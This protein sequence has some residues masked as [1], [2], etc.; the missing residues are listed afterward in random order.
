MKQK[1]L[2]FLSMMLLIGLVGA[3]F[4]TAQD[5]GIQDVTIRDL[6]TYD[7]L[8]SVLDIPDHPLA[9]EQVRITFVVVS[10][11]RTSGLASFN[12]NN[13]PEIGRIHI[14]I[15]D[16]A[17]VEL[18]RDGMSMQIVQGSGTGEFL[19]VENW[20]RGDVVTANGRMT[21]FDETAQFVVDEIEE[22]LG[23]VSEELDDLERFAPLL[24]PISLSPADFHDAIDAT[25]MSVNLDAYQKYH[26]AYIEIDGGTMTNFSGDEI[27][28]NFAIGQGGSV[29]PLRD[30]SLRFRNDR[31]E[32]RAGYNFRRPEDGA[33]VRPP[34][35]SSVRASGFLLMNNFDF[36]AGIDA[37]DNQGLHI[38]I[39][40]DGVL[41]VTEEGQDFRFENGVSLGGQF[42]WPVDFEVLAQPVQIVDA[43]QDPAGDVLGLEVTPTVT[44]DVFPPDDDAS[45]TITSVVIKYTSSISGTQDI[46]MTDIGGD[47]FEADLP[48]TVAFESVSYFIEATGSNGLT[49]RF[50]TFGTLGYFVDGGA[51][52]TIEQIQRTS[53]DLVG[54]SPLAGLEGLEFDIVGTVTSGAA[55]GVIALS[56]DLTPWS[57]IFLS[58]DANTASLNRGDLINITGGVVTEASIAN[59]NNTY[60]YI[61]NAEFSVLS[62]GNDLST[63]I[64]TLTT[65]E[66]NEPAAPGEA[67]E[68]MLLRFENVRMISDVG[69]GEVLFATVDDATNEVL[70]GT[71]VFNWDTRAGVIGETGFPSDLNRHAILGN[72]LDSVTGFVTF[73]FGVAKLIPRNLNDL[74]GDN[75]TVPRPLFNLIA[76]EEG[77][78]VGVIADTDIVVT[79][80]SLSPRDY[81]GD[82]VTFEWVLYNTDEEEIISLASDNDGA[83]AQITLSSDVVDNLL[84]DLGVEENESINVLW[85]VRA[86]DGTNSIV[87]SGFVA[88]SGGG[89]NRQV[90]E[91]LFAPVFRTLTLTRGQVTSTEDFDDLMPREF[92]L[93]QNFPNPFNPTTQINYT[94]PQNSHVRIDVYNI[95]GQRVATLVNREMA[96]G[97]H[98]VTFDATSLASGVYFY[99][100]QAGNTL[101][102]RKMTL[103]K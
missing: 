87:T 49:A 28:P 47:R 20:N 11:P 3:D 91:T 27:R 54:P 25:T 21:F 41:W 51:I 80:Q 102:T 94:L 55:D 58:L 42:Q 33:F 38:A 63:V 39:M 68:A 79:W 59:N 10:N 32:Y 78:D 2:S 95:V 98:D 50:P 30:V 6:N 37:V 17:A 34:I 57:G 84:A 85:N 96:A 45:V 83:D 65:D 86:S 70:D 15:T 24:D 90:G 61:A 31:Q 53:D 46:A 88:G 44:A 103:I 77:A 23:T 9:D 26:A 72:D 71:A 48:E 60:T 52:T 82:A 36:V 76:P 75:F 19:N 35:G 93:Q 16:T 22:F 92:A 74:E 4:A 43:Q 101:L 18:G 69:F 14:F 62:T 97:A 40:E 64:P 1:L 67:W 73:T 81:D 13:N 8:T 89:T 99:R 12:A 66:F 29:V 5:N 7:N 56:D 100:L